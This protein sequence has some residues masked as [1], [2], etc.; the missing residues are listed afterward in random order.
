M[1]H[2]TR[3]P[4]LQAG[5]TAPECRVGRHTGMQTCTAAPECQDCRHAP[6]HQSAG[7]AGMHHHT[8]FRICPL[9]LDAFLSRIGVIPY[10]VHQAFFFI[11]E[12]H[13]STSMCS[14][15]HAVEGTMS[16][17]SLVPVSDVVGI[18]SVQVSLETLFW[19]LEADIQKWIKHTV[20]LFFYFFWGNQYPVSIVTAPPGQ[21]FILFP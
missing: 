12:Y 6:P 19:F 17:P 10:A 20:V 3:V 7:M 5:S 21:C 15:V 1:H 9:I 18:M 14:F 11:N 16:L 8:G 2:R 13:P 4:G